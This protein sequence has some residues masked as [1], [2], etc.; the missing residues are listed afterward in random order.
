MS[1]AFLGGLFVI[2]TLGLPLEGCV[3]LTRSRCFC[4]FTCKLEGVYL[5][6]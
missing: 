6:K 2:I 1:E 5:T 4:S 3:L